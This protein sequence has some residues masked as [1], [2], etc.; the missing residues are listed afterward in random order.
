MAF[1]L[2]RI[3]KYVLLCSFFCLLHLFFSSSSAISVNISQGQTIKDG[4]TLI[5]SDEKFVLGFFSP[6]NSTSRYAGIWYNKIAVKTSV[7][8]ANRDRPIEGKSG[9]LTLTENGNLIVLNGN[10]SRVMFTNHSGSTS[11]N[12][13]ATL[14][15]TGNLQISN[16]GQ[17][18]WQS[19]NH[20]T[21]TFLP[22]MRVYPRPGGESKLFTSWR[23]ATDPSPGQYSMGMDTRASPQIVIWNGLNRRW[24]SGHWNGVQFS[25]VPVSTNFLYGFDYLRDQNNNWYLSYNEP[26]GSGMFRFLVS[27]DGIGK[28]LEWNETGDVWDAIQ[29]QPATECDVYNKCGVSGICKLNENSIC[30]CLHGFVPKNDEEW[31]SG[32]WSGGCL[33]NKG[34]ECGL[35]TNNNNGSSN[36]SQD[37]FNKVER[38][39]LPDFAD[40]IDVMNINECRTRCSNN[41]S[42]HAYAFDSGINCLFWGGD[43]LFDIQQF[44]DG[45]NDLY[46]RLAISELGK[47]TRFSIYLIIAIVVGGSF[48]VLFALWMIWRIRLRR[49]RRKN[50]VL[51]VVDGKTTGQTLTENVT[52]DQKTGPEVSIFSFNV[53]AVATDNFSEDNKLG[54]GGFGHVYKGKLTNGEEVAVKRLSA[55]SGQGLEE[56]TNEV[57]LIAKLQHI[58][59]V[60]LL[61]WCTEGGERILLYEYM[62]NKS[63]DKFLFDPTMNVQLD[64]KKRH[65]II[66]GIARGLIYLH[67]DSRLRIIH[68]DLKASNILLDEE[69]NPKISDFGMATIFG[70]KENEASTSR[71]VGTFGYMPPEYAMEGLFSVKSDVY[72]FGVLLLEIVSGRRNSSFRKPECSNIIQY[73]WDLWD[74]GRAMEM[75]D[76]TISGSCSE[77]E[78]LRCIH[79]AMLCVQDTADYRPTMPSVLQM[80]ETE[81]VTMPVPREPAFSSTRRSRDIDSG[82]ESQE[83]FSVN[84]ITITLVGGR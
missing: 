48:F 23:T 53:V 31:R 7:W 41:C 8:V 16:S 4:E 3:P 30:N 65:T 13:T 55:K 81:A 77:K 10:G 76:P 50:N 44:E 62:P 64:W 70:R 52:D 29:L 80:L 1:F 67:R 71:V 54:Q 35:T 46:V 59:L 84:D 22:E 36:G 2:T 39:K 5:S 17:V 43:D 34:L 9:S 26:E 37:G 51:P 38:V 14:M 68:R 75:I 63:L 21:D 74:N 27:F 18:I 40:R 6:E 24:R 69:M 19:F 33:R 78:V 11:G 73:A 82:K 45:G 15:D 56:F 12:F 58:N 60:R 83:K 49:K 57:M 79:V 47:K 66:Q 25:G 61:G 42:C 20:P 28:K 32:N 72:S